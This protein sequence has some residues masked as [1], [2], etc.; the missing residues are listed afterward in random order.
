MNILAALLKQEATQKWANGATPDFKANMDVCNQ[1]EQ[2]AGDCT[3][4][5]QQLS[6]LR[7]N[8][9]DASLGKAFFEDLDKQLNK[10]ITK[11]YEIIL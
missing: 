5:T 2:S 7:R 10:R 8:G 1:Q 9:Q 3:A 11:G 6:L 4:F